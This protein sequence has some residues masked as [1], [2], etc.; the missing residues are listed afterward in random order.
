MCGLIHPIGR[1]VLA[2][3]PAKA[4]LLALALRRLRALL[5]LGDEKSNPLYGVRGLETP[6]NPPAKLSESSRS[7]PWNLRLLAILP[8]CAA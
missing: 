7:G 8:L 6:S 2:N 1:N 3:D 5:S 4:I